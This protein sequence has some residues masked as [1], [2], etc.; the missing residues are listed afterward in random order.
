MDL[1]DSRPMGIT[2]SA[3]QIACEQ[4]GQQVKTLDMLMRLK[5]VVDSYNKAALVGP[6]QEWVNVSECGGYNNGLP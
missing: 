4:A 6:Y 1:E 3:V 5:F 2:W